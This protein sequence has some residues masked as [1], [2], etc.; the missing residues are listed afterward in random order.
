M[1]G[2]KHSSIQADRIIYSF[3]ISLFLL[4]HLFF[5]K[6]NA[7]ML[8]KNSTT[9]INESWFIPI[10]ILMIVCAV[11]VI[12][13]AVLFLFIIILDKTCHTV[14]MMLIASSCLG[15]LLSGCG[16]LRIWIFRLENDIKSNIVF[17][18]VCR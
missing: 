6:M 10:D 11:L 9:M 5:S 4:S 18:N 8:F 3:R 1:L 15:Q 13:S 14:P 16:V 17:Q 7:T 2:K 12:I